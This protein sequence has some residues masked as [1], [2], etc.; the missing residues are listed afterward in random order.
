MKNAV[1]NDDEMSSIQN[2]DRLLPSQP[3]FSKMYKGKDFYGDMERLLESMYEPLKL[4]IKTKDGMTYAVMGSDLNT[5]RFY[6]FLIRSHGYKKVLEL[7]TY[8]GA[9]AMYIA[10]AGAMVYTI[11][12][13]KE[14]HG[15]ATENIKNNK[16]Q[17]QIRCLQFDAIKYLQGDILLYDLIL[18]DCAKESYKEL[19][20]LSLPRLAKNGM[21][22]VDDVFFQGD[23][24]NQVSTS[25]KGAGVRR[26][27]DYVKTLEGY[28]KVILPIGN[29]L[30]M[31]RKK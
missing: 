12:T 18:I 17:R 25:E 26:M 29:G 7:G 5:L 19:L 8:I 31:I 11:E 21:I 23:T 22:L 9:S 4:D 20:E 6:Q 15:I 14:F 1:W 28:E 13:G 2:K 30:L 24:L 16:F 27:L 3:Y 10:D